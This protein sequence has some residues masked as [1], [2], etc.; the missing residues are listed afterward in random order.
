MK[1]RRLYDH[2]L[3]EPIGY[4]RF[5]MIL[6]E[7]G[8]PE[9]AEI[10]EANPSFENCM[11]M[12]LSEMKM[13]R[14]FELLFA[15]Y[16]WNE[17]AWLKRYYAVSYNGQSFTEVIFLEARGAHYEIGV[18]S[19]ARGEFAILF[20]KI[21]QQSV[22]DSIHNEILDH[23]PMAV[24]ITNVY[25]D[26]FYANS[27][28]ESVFGYRYEEVMECDNLEKLI[29][30]GNMVRLVP[31][32]RNN[33]T[34]TIQNLKHIVLDRFAKPHTLLIDVKRLPSDFEKLIV[35]CKDISTYGQE[36]KK[37]HQAVL[38]FANGKFTKSKP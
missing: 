18:Y 1:N 23:L 35:I 13:Y 3:K 19:P 25:G 6:N 22:L 5:K 32:T 20:K 15:F 37:A 16:R 26:I 38:V 14:K 27:A 24:F 31:K 10:L 33:G 34:T 9:D 36:K 28:V 4:A 7:D 21:M 17:K 29:G 30:K 2:Y 11:G 12:S 8:E